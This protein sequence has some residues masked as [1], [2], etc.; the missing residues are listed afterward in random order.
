MA[1]NITRPSVAL[2]AASH[3]SQALIVALLRAPSDAAPASI[4]TS[5]VLAAAGEPPRDP[6]SE[7]GKAYS[8][9]LEA[10]EEFARAC[11]D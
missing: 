7:A 1:N 4:V 5:A 2:E 3:A 9:L 6:N 11:E 8:A 10:L